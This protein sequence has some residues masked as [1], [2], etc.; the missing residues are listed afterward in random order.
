MKLDKQ[1]AIKL[2]FKMDLS[3]ILSM[4]L[5]QVLFHNHIVHVK[6]KLHQMKN[7]RGLVPSVN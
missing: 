1:I 7:V 2:I 3:A 6:H 4:V 5:A